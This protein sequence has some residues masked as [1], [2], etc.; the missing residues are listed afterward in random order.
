MAAG[1]E[2]N[3]KVAAGLITSVTTPVVVSAGVAASVAVRVRVDVPAAEGTPLM[4]QPAPRESPAGSV[5]AATLQPYGAVPPAIPTVVLYGT[6]VV[7]LG[8]VPVVSV[9]IAVL[10]GAVTVMLKMP[11][12]V[13][14]ALSC[15][16]AVKG[17][18]PCA[19]GVPEMMPVFASSVRPEGREP[20]TVLQR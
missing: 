13:A 16:W 6:P 14:P 7:P 12:A 11:V 4:A 5:P 17:K 19:T 1:G 8:K 18:L 2:L 9:S 20:P 3:I 15:T 10:V